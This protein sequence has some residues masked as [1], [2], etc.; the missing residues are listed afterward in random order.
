MKKVYFVCIPLM[1]GLICCKDETANQTENQPQ[2]QETITF[3]HVSDST[4]DKIA[5]LHVPELRDSANY[6]LL[7]NYKAFTEEYLR[8]MQKK[9][10]QKIKILQEESI[11][12][13]EKT[14]L[15]VGKLY[16][17]ELIKVDT[18]MQQLSNELN[19]LK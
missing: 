4:I 19:T 17:D 16:S 5:R 14:N 8:A 1:L 12:W 6:V 7:Q 18:F 2:K 3:L 13:T 15:F 10:T 11:Q 9:D